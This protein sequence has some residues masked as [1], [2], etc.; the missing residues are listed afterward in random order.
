MGDWLSQGCQHCRDSWS[1]QHEDVLPVVSVIEEGPVLL[2]RCRRCGA[3][4]EENLR[5]MHVVNEAEARRTFPD[6][7]PA[8]GGDA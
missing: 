8:S 4:W 3:W 1:R 7:F 2:R 5:E 6:A